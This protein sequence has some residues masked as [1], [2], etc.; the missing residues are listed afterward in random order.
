VK[1][2]RNAIVG[3]GSRGLTVFEMLAANQRAQKSGAKRDC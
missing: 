3:M 2:V 1:T